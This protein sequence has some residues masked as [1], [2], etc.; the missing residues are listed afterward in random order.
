MFSCDVLTGQRWLP[1][2]NGG[3]SIQEV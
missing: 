1:T 2:D 3:A